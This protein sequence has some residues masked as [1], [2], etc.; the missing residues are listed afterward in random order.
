MAPLPEPSLEE[1]CEPQTPPFRSMSFA[2]PSFPEIYDVS[3]CE[4]PHPS[5]RRK[6]TG[7][8]LAGLRYERKAKAFLSSILPGTFIPG[9]WFSYRRLDDPQKRFCQPDGFS[10]DTASNALT[11]FEV[12]Y[13]WCG[14]AAQQLALYHRVLWEALRPASVRLVCVTRSFDPSIPYEGERARIIYDLESARTGAIQ[15]LIWK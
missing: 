4:C 15:V 9:P 10:L 8:Q 1:L 11:I 13:G 5:S 3:R 6:P 14:E 2:P 12:K 7:A